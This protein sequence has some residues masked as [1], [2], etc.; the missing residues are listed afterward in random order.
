MLSMAVAARDPS[1]A[2]FAPI[3]RGDQC[4]PPISTR[5]PLCA[6]RHD[7]LPN[8]VRIGV[9]GHGGVNLDEHP[10]RGVKR[11]NQSANSE[12]GTHGKPRE[13]KH[14]PHV[15]SVWLCTHDEGGPP[16]HQLSP[17]VEKVRS[18]TSVPL[19]SPHRPPRLLAAEGLDGSSS[20]QAVHLAGS[21]A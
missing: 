16:A 12:E 10:Q 4:C 21:S 8:G 3:G 6:V 17:V 11:Q 2:A 14:V 15:A 7:P 18:S 20:N 5:K 19:F 1:A 9:A 13:A